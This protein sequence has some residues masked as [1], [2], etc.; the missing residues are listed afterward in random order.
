M[1]RKDKKNRKCIC[2]GKTLAS[3]QKLRQHYKSNK[4]QCTSNPPSQN[5]ARPQLSEAV[6]ETVNPPVN[7]IN[8]NI[9]EQWK[10][11]HI[12]TKQFKT[13]LSRHGRSFISNEEAEK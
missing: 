7:M 2:C 1:A 9:H 10:P 6:P 12:N 8:E 4:N 5:I 3:S 11:P 13:I